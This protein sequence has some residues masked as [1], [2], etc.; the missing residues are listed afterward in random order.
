MS[1]RATGLGAGPAAAVIVGLDCITGLQS[2]RILSRHGVPVIGVAS[3]PRHPC[4]RTRA[5]ERVVAMETDGGGLI[6]GLERLGATLERP[7]VLLP[8]TDPSVLLLARHRAR[9]RDRFHLPLPA[10]DVVEMLLDKVR[11]HALADELGL[12][13]P[14]TLVLRNRSQAERAA[15][16]LRFPC[17]LKPPLKTAVWQ[18]KVGEKVCRVKDAEELLETYQRCSAWAGPL[19]AQE[20]IGGPDSE[21]YSCNCSYSARGE[22]IVTFVARK[23]RQ[24][25]PGAGTSSLG[26]ECRNDEVR[27]LALR[28]FGAVGFRGLGY[29]E[30][31]RDPS[32][33][34]HYVIEANVGRPTGRS[35][36]AE[37]GGVE[38]LYATYADCLGL[39]LPANL[40][41]RYVGAKW[42]FLRRD[43]RSA[44]HY[45]RRGELT[46]GEWRR[47]WSGPMRFAMASRTDPLPFLADLGLSLRRLGRR[48]SGRGSRTPR[49]ES[50]PTPDSPGSVD[51]PV[52]DRGGEKAVS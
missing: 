23:L 28:L 1:V 45:W 46:L 35:A 43:L 39:P 4:C 34:R 18:A 36:I 13:L 22:P 17:L 14:R 25:P 50:V 11:F 47:S 21:L 15:R 24:W 7:A 52:L 8:C 26:E 30:V 44:L 5:C 9:L 41:Q 42:I 27:A 48:L 2:A 51:P 12:P 16:E 33:G 49:Q 32:T 19:V 20:W 31:K 6:E 10:T 29:L 38:L 37:A 3:D 40:E